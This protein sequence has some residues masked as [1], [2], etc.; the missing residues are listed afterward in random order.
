MAF[1][2]EAATAVLADRGAERLRGGHVWIFAGDI[3]G[4]EPGPEPEAAAAVRV[5]DRRG[6]LLGW[7]DHNPRSQIRL[8]L[9]TRD[10]VATPDRE[11]FRLRMAAALAYRQSV[12]QDS[13]AFRL[14]ASEADGLPGF[15]V[16]LY[17]SALSFQV[18]TAAMA[19]RQPALLEDLNTLLRPSVVVERNEAKIRSREGLELRQGLLHGDNAVVEVEI[20]HLKFGFDLL[21]GQ[22]TGGFLDQRENWAATAAWAARFGVKSAL[23]VFT[24]QGGFALHLAHAVPGL[25]LEGVDGSRPALEAAEANF[26]RNRLPDQ[27]W[28]EANA[29]DLLRDYDQQRRK[30]DLVVLDPPAFAKSRSNLSAAIAGYKEINLRALKLLPPGGL[31]VTCSCSHHLDENGFLAMLQAAAS[32]AQRGLVVIERR[33]QALDHPVLLAVPETRYLKYLLVRV[34]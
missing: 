22:K 1:T 13:N 6:R 20:N 11:F 25:Q 16:D 8:R 32:D 4:W 31:L 26:R 17:G 33:G 12:V 29:F 19:A 24:Y 5:R 21:A 2:P 18:L 27:T 7:A 14:I 28:I 3:L 10:P 15:I 30:V 9:L 23:D 34:V